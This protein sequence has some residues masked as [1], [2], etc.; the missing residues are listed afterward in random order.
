[1][2]TCCICNAESGTMRI[3]DGNPDYKGKPICKTCKKDRRLL[4]DTR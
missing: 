1:M 4:M 2:A 3:N